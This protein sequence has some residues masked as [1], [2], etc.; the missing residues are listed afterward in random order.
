MAKIGKK[1]GCDIAS[2]AGRREGIAGGSHQR[3]TG[4]REVT[5]SSDY[6]SSSVLS[7]QRQGGEETSEVFVYFDYLSNTDR[8]GGSHH[9]RAVSF[10]GICR[11]KEVEGRSVVSAVYFVIV[12]PALFCYSLLRFVVSFTFVCVV[13]DLHRYLVT[14]C[15]FPPSMQDC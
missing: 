5:K 4:T 2:E 6:E 14:L 3:R 1:T 9:Y 15:P 8:Q 13:Y 7:Y 10:K 11:L 12:F